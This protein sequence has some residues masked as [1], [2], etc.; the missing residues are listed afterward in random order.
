MA[1]FHFR[2]EFFLRQA[3]SIL[4]SFELAHTMDEPAL[5]SDTLWLRDSMPKVRPDFVGMEYHWRY[6]ESVHEVRHRHQ[7]FLNPHPQGGQG[8]C[9]CLVH[10]QMLNCYMYIVGWL[11]PCLGPVRRLA[12]REAPWSLQRRLL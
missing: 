10:A 7:H 11:S 4:T 8:V 6:A 1:D 9:A 2:W 3:F 12:V 5:E